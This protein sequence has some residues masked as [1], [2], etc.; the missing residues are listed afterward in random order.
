MEEIE[1]FII[2][3]DKVGDEPMDRIYLQEAEATV[4]IIDDGECRMRSS[5]H[6]QFS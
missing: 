1:E 3:L 5:K 4:A 2:R 6:L